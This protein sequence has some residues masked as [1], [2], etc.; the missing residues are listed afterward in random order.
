MMR[1]RSA[2][3]LT[4]K[5]HEYGD[6]DVPFVIAVGTYIHDRER[7]HTTDAMYGALAVELSEG[8]DGEMVTREIR[9][10]DGYFGVPPEWQ[11]RNVSGVL[12]VN[13]LMPYYVQRAEVTLW[14]HPNPVHALP[15]ELG[16]PGDA[17]ALVAGQLKVIPQLRPRTS[18]SASRTRGRL[19]RRGRTRTSPAVR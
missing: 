10:P 19:V 16:V 3:P 1:P 8:P 12:R 11:H 13:Q 15:D 2:R 17:V 14:R 9:Q 4:T 7:W 18:S 5:H 6:L